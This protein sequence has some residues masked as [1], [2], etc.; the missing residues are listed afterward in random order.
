MQ[1]FAEIGIAVVIGS[2]IGISSLYPGFVDAEFT[3]P[4]RNAYFAL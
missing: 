2:K 1:V 3:I 4:T